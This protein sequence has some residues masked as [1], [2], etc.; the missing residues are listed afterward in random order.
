MSEKER[1]EKEIKYL[2][3]LKK[4]LIK[5]TRKEVKALR[6]ELDELNGEKTL[7]RTMNK[8]GKNKRR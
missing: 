1:R 7:Q 3:Y 5:Q 2:L 8:N 4:E 6:T